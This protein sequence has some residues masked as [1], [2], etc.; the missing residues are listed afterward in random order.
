[1]QNGIVHVIGPEN[2]ITL[3]GAIVWEIHHFSG[4][5]RLCSGWYFGG[6][7][8]AFYTM[9]MQPKPKKMHQRSR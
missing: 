6:R 2:G 4:A 8:G 1:M 3:P 5:F 9:Y 7:N